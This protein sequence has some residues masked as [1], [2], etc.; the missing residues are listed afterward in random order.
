MKY[1][2][3]LFIGILFVFTTCSNDKDKD[4]HNAIT[5]VNNSDKAIYYYPSSEY[6]DTLS[7]NPNPATSGNDFRIE[8]FS[9]KQ[10][11]YRS[12]IEGKFLIIYKYMY[13]IYDA[14]IL[15]TTPWDTVVKKYMILKRYELTLQDLQKSNWTITFP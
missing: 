12:C 9:S 5:I 7:L 4:C 2:T 1:V 10:D 6:P 13:F 14:Q 8:K 3:F 11:E 15:E